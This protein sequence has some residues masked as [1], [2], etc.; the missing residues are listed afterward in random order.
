MCTTFALISVTVVL[1]A[2]SQM[3]STAPNPDA[4]PTCI[5]DYAGKSVCHYFFITTSNKLYILIQ[6]ACTIHEYCAITQYSS[7]FAPF[8]HCVR[9]SEC[10]RQPQKHEYQLKDT[11]V[12]WTRNGDERLCCCMGDLCNENTGKGNHTGEGNSDGAMRKGSGSVF[13]LCVGVL[14][15]ARI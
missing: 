2:L 6:I 11:C 12:E 13:G 4:G 3:C 8:R 10:K 9:R 15:A 7:S 1:I 14:I 5:D